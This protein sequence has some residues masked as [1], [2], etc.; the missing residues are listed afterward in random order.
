MK[1]THVAEIDPMPLPVEPPV[2][3][4]EVRVLLASGNA[5][6]LAEF[7]ALCAPLDVTVLGPHEWQAES[8]KTLPDVAETENTFLGNA[9][10]KAASAAR[11][12][13]LTVLADDSGLSVVALQG[14]PG[15]HSARYA[16]AAAT[17][18]DNRALLL[19][20]LANVPE[21]KRQAAFHCVLVLCG[22]L[23]EGAGCGRTADGL[24]WRAFDGQVDG[25]ILLTEVG[26][27]GFGYDCLFQH[28]GLNATF[29]EA[30]PLAKNALSHR[31][32]A[33][34][35]L[36]TYLMALPAQAS[37]GRPMYLRPAGMQAL[38][39]AIDGVLGRHLRHA[40]AALEQALGDRPEL[41]AKERA[42][43]AELHWHTLRRLSFLHLARLAMRGTDV[44]S[45]APDPRTLLRN[46]APLLACLAMCDVDPSGQQRD[47]STKASGDSALSELCKRNPGFAANL[48]ESLE[49]LDA[50]L[51][52]ATW[53]LSKL[54]PDDREAMELGANPVLWRTMKQE[55]GEPHA[56]LAL[57]YLNQRGPLTVR[58]NPMRAS[59]LA[60]AQELEEAGI[61][62]VPL[63]DLPNALMCL[64]A[65]RLTRLQLFEDGGFEVQ[66]E[67]SQRITAAANVKPGDL[68]LDWCAGAGG[69]SL[70][71]AAALAGK[72]RLIA[73]D[74][75]RQR[76]DECERRL[77][78]AGV[79]NAETR[80]LQ[81]AKPPKALPE[82]DVVL[83]DAPCT[84][85]GALRRNPEL[86]WA[87]D[88][89][90]LGRFPEQQLSILRRASEHV[91]PGGRLV[92]ATCSL[93]K[94][95]NESIVETFLAS[96]PQFQ[97]LSETRVGPAS[98]DYLATMPLA[99]IGPDGFYFCV[100]TRA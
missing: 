11:A 80:W 41:G 93:L 34:A 30:D 1:M 65:G 46:E 79:P 18:A 21:G 44:P 51:R 35:K 29:A 48:P 5:H 53:A 67:G 77:R 52:S 86:R 16:G 19:K 7:Q 56:R 90:W 10:L 70:G 25:E 15:V 62:T 42:A 2:A 63:A 99:P 3:A 89:T 83:V 17:D 28:A 8:G 40:D 98:G 72:G 64:Q 12:T 49:R 39:H 66:D 54:P 71:L 78:R 58:A 43:I 85:T 31:G 57:Q 69:K 36:Q 81:G 14:A 6:K 87:I 94:R 97:K 60:V 23:A 20:N 82:G 95:E 38:A 68:V 22:P 84:S 32:R 27:G 9:L 4:P 59:R 92:Y 61:K 45:R 91:K 96:S 33:F 50:A 74:T 73:L 24:A 47:H 100:L 26:T 88:E 75:H 76:L 13:G 37:K 55:L